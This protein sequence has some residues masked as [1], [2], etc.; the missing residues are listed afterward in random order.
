MPAGE[1]GYAH[2]KAVRIGGQVFEE[3]QR[4]TVGRRSGGTAFMSSSQANDGAVS[5][6]SDE[7]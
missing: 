4:R 3:E 2:S 5:V 1:Y 6:A 7:P